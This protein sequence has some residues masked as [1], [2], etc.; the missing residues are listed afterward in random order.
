MRTIVSL[1][2]AALVMA[3]PGV[4]V[5]Q[6]APTTATT[7][8]PQLLKKLDRVY[9]AASQAGFVLSVTDN[10][11]AELRWRMA[12]DKQP[13]SLSFLGQYYDK[14]CESDQGFCVDQD[15]TEMVLT[16]DALNTDER[17]AKL[18]IKPIPSVVHQLLAHANDGEVQY[19][20]SGESLSVQFTIDKPQKPE[21]VTD[22]EKSSDEDSDKGDE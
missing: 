2:L 6:D 8:N 19:E 4:V 22:G 17:T 11:E 21:P 14:T 20:R 9:K 7:D 12:L 10:I 18:T 15:G 5:A 1:L 16:L 3:A 13:E